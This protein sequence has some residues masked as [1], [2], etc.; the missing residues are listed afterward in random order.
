[1]LICAVAMCVALPYTGCIVV[2]TLSSF[3]LNGKAEE[4]CIGA[5]GL[6]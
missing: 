6:K 1:M 5:Q 2:G 4:Q 3:L